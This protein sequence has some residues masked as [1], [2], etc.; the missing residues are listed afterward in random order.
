MFNGPG[1]AARTSAEVYKDE[2]IVGFVTSGSHGPS[3]GKNVGMAYVNKGL[4][5]AGTELQV[6]VRNKFYDVTVKKMP[7]TKPGYYRGE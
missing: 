7:L 2:E 6:K 3:V 4:N 5:K 1:P